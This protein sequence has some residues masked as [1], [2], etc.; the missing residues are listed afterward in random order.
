M[1]GKTAGVTPPKATDASGQQEI[2]DE[3]P[4]EKAA[5]PGLAGES[6]K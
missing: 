3:R 5:L 1:I 2:S 4:G 6:P